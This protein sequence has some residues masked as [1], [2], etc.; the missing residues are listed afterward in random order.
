MYHFAAFSSLYSQVHFKVIHRPTK[1]ANFAQFFFCSLGVLNHTYNQIY[2]WMILMSC[3]TKSINLLYCSQSGWLLDL[4]LFLCTNARTQKKRRSVWILFSEKWS[5]VNKFLLE[6]SIVRLDLVWFIFK[7]IF[8]CR[9]CSN[10]LSL[11]YIYRNTLVRSKP[12][13]RKT[14]NEYELF[15]WWKQIMP[16]GLHRNLKVIRFLLCFFL[17]RS[18]AFTHFTVF[19]MCVC[20]IECINR[21]PY[22]SQHYHSSVIYVLYT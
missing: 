14:C 21:I 12:T 10:F 18:A 2:N 5:N 20:L 17:L 7:N 22:A 9:I 15:Q 1:S 8:S 19:L 11:Y 3:K 6:C 4:F 13:R 16:K